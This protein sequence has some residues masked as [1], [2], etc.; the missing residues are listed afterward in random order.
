MRRPAAT[1]RPRGD[2]TQL[3]AVALPTRASAH[4]KPNK[5]QR[6]RRQAAREA[7]GDTLRADID[8]AMCSSALLLQRGRGDERRLQVLRDEVLALIKLT[9]DASRT[10]GAARPEA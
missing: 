2:E 9:K 1:A 6:Q 4:V 10:C 7:A 3:P 8:T 5:A